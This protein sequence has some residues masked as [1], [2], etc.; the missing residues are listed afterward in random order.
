MSR[1]LIRGHPFRRNPSP[2]DLVG[3]SSTVG[4]CQLANSAAIES[5][6]AGR[7]G[8]LRAQTQ[9]AAWRPSST[10]TRMVTMAST[11]LASDGAKVHH[12]R[13]TSRPV[14]RSATIPPAG[15]GSPTRKAPKSWGKDYGALDNRGNPLYFARSVKVVCLEDGKLMK[16]VAE[17]P[18]LG[19]RGESPDTG[20]KVESRHALRLS[21][22]RHRRQ[23]PRLADLSPEVRQPL[24]H[25][26]RLLLADLRPPARR[27]P[28]DASRS[29]C[30]TPTACSTAGRCCCR[31]RAA[32]CAS[33]TTPTAAT[34]RRK[35][36]TTRST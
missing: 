5:A 16:P 14:P 29:R 23:G 11:S 33:S 3:P 34:R 32:A 17:L 4:V 36:S 24:Q 20:Q 7:P 9:M 28:L 10:P 30:T 25:A 22:D 15:S 31:I 35:P 26:S 19:K 27:R 13:L 21:A 18:P 1:S 2:S 8:S 12:G 6:T